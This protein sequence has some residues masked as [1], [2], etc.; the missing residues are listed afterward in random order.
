MM[1]TTTTSQPH[2]RNTL[3]VV[4]INN[5]KTEQLVRERHVFPDDVSLAEIVIWKVSKVMKGSGHRYKYR[6]GYVIEEVCVL[7]YDNEQGKG[8]RRHL[9]NIV[10]P[11]RFKDIDTL[12]AD[13]RKDIERWRNEHG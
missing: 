2:P 4:I 12:L 13:F 6:M 8:D 5:M 10:E 9:G 3:T 11:Y 7:R 1:R